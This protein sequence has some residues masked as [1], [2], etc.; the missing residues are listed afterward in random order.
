MPSENFA[1]IARTESGDYPVDAPFDPARSYPEYSGAVSASANHA[2]EGVREA[3][4][5]AGLDR[6]RFDTP[7]WNPLGE[8]VR[9]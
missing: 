6:Q 1:S 3:L 2:Y 5:L 8:F 7:A 4:R 9:P